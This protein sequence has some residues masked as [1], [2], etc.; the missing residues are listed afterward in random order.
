MYKCIVPEA[1]GLRAKWD[2]NVKELEVIERIGDVSRPELCFLTGAIGWGSC[3]RPAVR[4]GKRTCEQPQHFASWWEGGD[5]EIRVGKD[6]SVPKALQ[7]STVADRLSRIADVHSLPPTSIGRT[8]I[9][10][11]QEL[12]CGEVAQNGSYLQ[13]ASRYQVFLLMPLKNQGC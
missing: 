10:I 11:L 13:L 3:K 8:L 4:G 7:E 2:E 6:R 9:N 5:G 12:G 1:N